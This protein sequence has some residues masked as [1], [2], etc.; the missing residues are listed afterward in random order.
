MSNLK[1]ALIKKIEKEKEWNT[2]PEENKAEL[3]QLMIN[4]AK[5][6]R[7]KAEQRVQ[8]FRTK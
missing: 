7:Q 1:K 3:Q 6:A 4:G 2:L 8:F 5:Q